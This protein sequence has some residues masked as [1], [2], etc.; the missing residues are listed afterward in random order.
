M[1]NHTSKVGRQLGR[2]KNT[3][4]RDTAKPTVLSRSYE[5]T[6]EVEK[7]FPRELAISQW[8]PTD[9]GNIKTQ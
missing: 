9:Q 3:G 1:M 5:V 4:H 7:E 6:L 2:Q 8:T